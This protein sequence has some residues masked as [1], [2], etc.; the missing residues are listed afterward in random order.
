MSARRSQRAVPI[1][2]REP[3]LGV[4]QHQR[5]VGFGQGRGGLLAQP[6][7]QAFRRAFVESRGV[8]RGEREMA[9]T[10][11]TA[12]PVPGHSGLGIDQRPARPDQAIEQRGFADVRPADDG[13]A[14]DSV[15]A[16][17]AICG[18]AVGEEL[19]VL[20]HEVDGALLPPGGPPRGLA[21]PGVRGSRRC[22]AKG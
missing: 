3:A 22:T 13:D 20:G 11:L 19:S 7:L 6:A 10:R 17:R 9:E 16:G 21:A 4:D 5:D 18:S 1:E 12:E 15:L 8:D 2:R 14:G